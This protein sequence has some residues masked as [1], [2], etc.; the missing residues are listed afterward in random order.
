VNPG[1]RTPKEL[2][3]TL[4]FANVFGVLSSVTTSK[5][6]C[7]FRGRRDSYQVPV[8]LAE[9]ELLDSFITDAY[10][11]EPV[12]LLSKGLPARLR[13]RIL[14]RR[15]SGIPDGRVKSLWKSTLFERANFR[16][17]KPESLVFAPKAAKFS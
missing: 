5:Y 2:A 4:K 15:A 16:L 17:G 3:T 6:V 10:A 13:E 14:L 8:A 9:S 1:F 7:A 12:Q 11:S